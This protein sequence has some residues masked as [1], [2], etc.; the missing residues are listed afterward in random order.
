MGIRVGGIYYDLDLDDKQFNEKIGKAEKKV[1]GL[2]GQ[3]KKAEKGSKIFTASVTAVGT[4]I[5]SYAVKATLT[6]SRTETLGIAMEA[7]AKATGTSMEELK[8]QEA[9]L[10]KQGITTQE[11]RQTLTKF[12]QSQLDVTQASKL[13][14][15]A[16]D[17]AVISGENSSETTGRLTDAIA[18][19]NPMLLR[20]VGIVKSSTQIFDKHAKTL[21]K[22]VDDLTEVEKKQALVNTIFE[23]GK[24]VAGSYESAMDSVGKKTGSL[25]RYFEEAENII[26][27]KFLPVFGL[28][29][30]K[31]TEFLKK[32]TPETVD[33]VFATLNEWLPIIAG[34]IAGGVTPALIGMAGALWT[35]LAPLWPFILAGLALGVAFKALDIDMGDVATFI[36]EKLVPAFII[37]KEKILEAWQTIKEKWE[38]YGQPIFDYI[39]WLIEEWIIPAWESLKESITEA[40]A[41]AGLE[42]EDF[43]KILTVIAVIIGVMVVGAVV[44]LIGIVG[45]LIWAISLAIKIFT[46]LRKEGKKQFTRLKNSIIGM[47]EDLIQKLVN[48][49]D[50]IKNAIVKPFNEAKDKIAGIVAKIKETADKINPFHRESPSLVDNVKKG[51]GMIADEYARLG[52]ITLKPVTHLAGYGVAGN[53]TN[54]IKNDKN[55]PSTGQTINISLSPKGIFARS[56][57]ELR[58]ISLDML[59]AINEDLTARGLQSLGQSKIRSSSNG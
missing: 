34:V 31:V 4:A 57:G 42:M 58:D 25:K 33:A 16:Q 54:I 29:V 32:V 43:K 9:L 28:L 55:L 3:F 36:K 20:Q 14:R 15:V 47:W 13:A 12:M 45:A 46:T 37:M 39:V 2:A 23:E 19:M 26:G 11:A 52:D 41:E 53:I 40:L 48:L 50:N 56:R 44:I 38:E 49:K 30:D 5:A 27:E 1:D 17:L 6:A 8:K 35:A 10:R 51:I 21:G 24:K 59:D 22:N 18:T 7:V